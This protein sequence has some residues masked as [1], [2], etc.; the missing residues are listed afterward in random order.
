MSTL[1]DR[2]RAFLIHELRVA[3]T[4]LEDMQVDIRAI[5]SGLKE[6]MINPDEAV[7]ILGGCNLLQLLAI[8]IGEEDE[9]SRPS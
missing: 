2:R 7:G 5:A 9:Q 8:D 6:G 1:A 4:L 3:W